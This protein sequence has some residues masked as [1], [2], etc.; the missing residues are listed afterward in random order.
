MLNPKSNRDIEV[1]DKSNK[2]DPFNKLFDK[3]GS[4]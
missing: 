2:D 4:G 3:L 1:A